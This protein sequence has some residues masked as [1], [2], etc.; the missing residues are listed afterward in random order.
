MSASTDTQTTVAAP[1]ATSK[2]AKRS[3]P[4]RYPLKYH[5][6]ITPAM[7]N[8]L[9]RLTGRNSIHDE[10]DIGRMALHEFLL[11]NDPQYLRKVS[12]GAGNHA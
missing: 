5:C 12:N 4:E 6:S 2:T 8:S 7:A 1:A 10:A 11:K 9:R 3:R